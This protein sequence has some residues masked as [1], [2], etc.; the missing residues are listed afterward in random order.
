VSGTARIDAARGEGGATVLTLAGR[1]D[2]ESTGEVWREAMSIARRAGGGGLV[3]EASGLEYCDGAGAAL[4]AAL[5][6]AHEAAGGRF[7]LRG[8]REE[9]RRL[10]E[11]VE[12]SSE[13]APAAPPGPAAREPS[14]VEAAGRTALAIAADLRA[15]VVFLG[16]LTVV[17]AR[18]LRRP[19]EIRFRDAVAVADAA[20]AG[21]TPIMVGVGFLLGLILAFQGAIPMKRFAA[22]I[23]VADLIG[24]SMLRELGPLMASVLLTARSGSA[25]AAEIGTMKVNEEIDAL[26][27]MGIEPV[28]FLVVPRVLAA[29]AV[30]PALAMLTSLAGLVGGGVVYLS[31]GFPLVTYVN[32]IV[33]MVGGGDVLGGLVKSMVFGVIV[34]GI[35]C[36]RGLQAG[37]GARA[38]GEATTSS[39]VS[40]IV[41]IA[42]ADG[43][44][45]VLFYVLGF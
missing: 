3:V 14:L 29:V 22:E 16:E 23:F 27:T 44:F 9:L 30:V 20:G 24:L 37:K 15:L 4:L 38:V 28:R 45:A 10:V 7:E 18:A 6:E 31:L 25:F 17:L 32:R 35:G 33:D 8:L 39:V 40:G 34:A 43:I 12:P 26:T 2:A 1:L 42:I 19:R 5:R 13:A 36:L 21:A 11:L 41:A